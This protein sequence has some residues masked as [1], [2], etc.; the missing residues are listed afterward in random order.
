MKNRFLWLAL[1]APGLA[2]AAGPSAQEILSRTAATYKNLKSC[3]FRVTVQVIRDANVSEL[4]F[5]ESAA[6]P[7]K[8]RVQYDDPRGALIVGDGQAGWVF[9]PVAGEYSK[10]PL[11]AGP[12]N[13][14]G[15]IDQHV[16]NASIAREELFAVDG[17]PTPIYVVR[18]TRD[19]W[20]EGGLGLPGAQYAM[21]RIDQKT[22]KVYKV[23]TYA[24]GTTQILLYSIVKW[25]EPLPESL[26]AFTPP[27]SAREAAAAPAAKAEGSPI[28][29]TEAPDFTLSDGGGHPV[30][31]RDLRGKV[32]VVDFWATWCPPC[33]AQMPLLQK[34]QS[35]LAGKGL[36]VLGLDVGEDAEQVTKFAKQQSYTFTL[37]LG[38][39]PDVSA[40]YYVEAYPT[41][42]VVDRQG[43]IAFRELG[44]GEA[45]K[46]RSSV[47][48]A[49][50][51]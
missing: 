26:F 38:A 48:S 3:Q 24:P 49:L 20:P 14:F 16:T 29:G 1:I 40:K 18:V 51:Q 23:I 9:N 35:E 7:G 10:A 44:G 5:T 41:T 12:I 50:A 43:R 30:H 31:L 2:L 15:Q 17:K 42:F 21:Y 25:D 32:V 28:A 45:D 34:M 37:L 8:Y 46:L 11:G 4:R 47:E 22:F 33:R 27:A 13:N 39:E 19:R 6:G 36:V